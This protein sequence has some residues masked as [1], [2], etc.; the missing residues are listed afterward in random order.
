MR[1]APYAALLTA[2]ALWGTNPV[3]GRLIGVAVPPVTLSWLRWLAVLCAVAPF[4]WPRRREMVAAMRSHWRVLLVLAALANVPQSALVYKGL[5]TTSAVNVGLLNSS[6]PVLILLIGALFFAR[7]VARREVA[8]IAL[9]LLGVAMLLFQGSLERVLALSLNRG[10]LFAFGGML[11]WAWY[12]L[13][14]PRRPA[15]PLLAFVFCMSAIGVA[16]GAPAVLAEVTLDR[17]PRL[18]GAALLGIALIAAGPT[19][20]GTLA[21]SYGAERVGAVQAGVFVHFM[22][23]FATLFATMFLNESVRAYH[24]AGFALVLAG[25]LLALD[26]SRL[27]SSRP[28]RPLST[29]GRSHG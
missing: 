24:L 14:L 6:I 22:P 19:L 8:G 12:T 13:L 21:Y 17:P 2:A 16:L 1:Y 7:P 27:L 10:D 4:V 20:G 25:A 29:T 9:S 15:L 5:E 18:D 23:V 26:S 3:L 11:T 28:P